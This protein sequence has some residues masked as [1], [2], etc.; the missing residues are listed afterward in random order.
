MLIW[1]GKGILAFPPAILFGAFATL[2]MEVTPL[3]TRPSWGV[4]L[5]LGGVTAALLLWW[6][7]RWLERR[8]PPR[9]VVDQQTGQQHILKRRDTFFFVPLRFF[10]YVYGAAAVGGAVL[11]VTS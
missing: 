5:M 2:T 8:N 4:G 7:D 6:F 11:L 1:Q 3:E 10:P 9:T